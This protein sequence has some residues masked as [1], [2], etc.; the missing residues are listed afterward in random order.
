MGGGGGGL[1]GGGGGGATYRGHAC[2]VIGRQ[3]LHILH[4][5]VVHHHLER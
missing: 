4:T 3:F 1:V 2:D 5:F